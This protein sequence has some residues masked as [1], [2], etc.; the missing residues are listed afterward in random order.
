MANAADLLTRSMN[1]Q[2]LPY[3]NLLGQMTN[4]VFDNLD[5]VFEARG[6]GYLLDKN[7]WFPHYTIPEEFL[8]QDDDVEGFNIKLLNYYRENWG[9][10][11]VRIERNL[12]NYL[13]DDETKAVFHEALTAHSMRIYRCVPRTLISEIERIVRVEFYGNKVGS[14]SVGGLIQDRFSKSPVSI[15]PDRSFWFV[16]FEQL[17]GHIYESIRD[18]DTRLQFSES[19]VPNRH[20]SLHGLISYSSEQN[21]LNSIFIAEYV[22]QLITAGKLLERDVA[23]GA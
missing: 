20:A 6:K 8:N 12:P 5:F 19:S 4:A 3:V 22:M 14:F 11:R 7:G 23:L 18:A 1:R 21:S 9:E 17:T 10:I 2:I 16:G 15:F 13:V